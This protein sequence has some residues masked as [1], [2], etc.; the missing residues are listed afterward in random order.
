MIGREAGL[1]TSSS[2][3]SSNMIS[4]RSRLASASISRAVSAMATPAFMSSV[5]GPQS[6]PPL[7]RHGMVFK[8]P[9]GQTVSR[10]PRRRMGLAVSR[11]GVERG[12]KRA[13]S[14]LPW[15]CCRC[16]LT[17]PPSC[18]S[19]RG[20]ECD[21]GVDCGFRVG[22]RLG[23]NEFAG[24]I[25]KRALFAARPGEQGAHGDGICRIERH[26]RPFWRL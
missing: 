7:R 19:V 5:P 4:R 21:A 16:N 14:A 1:P 26:L 18:L 10:W 25:E 15:C 9:N 8:V 12:P 3:L 23:L 17:R 13:S 22:G 20:G 11:V 2:P 24:E 6:R